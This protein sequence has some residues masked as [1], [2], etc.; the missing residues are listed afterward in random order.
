MFDTIPSPL[1]GALPTTPPPRPRPLSPGLVMWCMPFYTFILYF[2][3][4]CI[5]T[6]L[7]D[8]SFYDLGRFVSPAARPR[9]G[10]DAACRWDAR[11]LHAAARCPQGIH[12][13]RRNAPVLPARP[14]KVLC[15][16]A[17]CLCEA[18]CLR[19][20][21][22]VPAVTP[23]CSRASLCTLPRDRI[24]PRTADPLIKRRPIYVR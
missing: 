10:E 13:P 18:V 4:P 19:P 23:T 17:T 14:S 8:A 20:R 7:S 3:L 2:F 24:M 5:N 21:L 16:P 15:D 6:C 9:Y 11:T 12:K 1:Q 22:A